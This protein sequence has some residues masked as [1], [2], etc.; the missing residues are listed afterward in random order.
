MLK[1]FYC[2]QLQAQWMDLGISLTYGCHRGSYFEHQDNHTKACHTALFEPVEN[3]D[4]MV[5]QTPAIQPHGQ[6]LNNFSMP[7]LVIS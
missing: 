5:L 7:I 3:A 4:Y 1:A 2:S 6:Q